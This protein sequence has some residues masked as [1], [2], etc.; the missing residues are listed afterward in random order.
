MQKTIL[1]ILGI[2]IVLGVA[3]GGWYYF[4]FVK[5]A[6]S[7]YVSETPAGSVTVDT[8]TGQTSSSTPTFTMAQVAEHNSITS[9][10]SVINTSVYDLTMW[11]NMHP[12]GK[13]AILSLCGINGT[14]AFM[15]QHHGG[16]K[17]MN[18]LARYK[19]GNLI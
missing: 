17:F 2:I 14:N 12:G 16:A 15:N 10:Y 1:W 8:T 9:C 7:T 11:V 19:I 6:P 13:Q 18:I 5:Y 4:N 3:G